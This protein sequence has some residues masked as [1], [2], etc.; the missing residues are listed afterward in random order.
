[1]DNQS[2]FHFVL[3][4]LVVVKRVRGY[5]CIDSVIE[6]TYCT[7]RIFYTAYATLCVLLLKDTRDN[8]SYSS[9]RM[10]FGRSGT[11]KC[12]E[13]LVFSFILYEI[14]MLMKDSKM[15][16]VGDETVS[17]IDLDGWRKKP[18]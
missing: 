14:Y 3:P 16:S 7:Y 13:F 12:N 5:H 4:L 17:Y 2:R 15:L 9:G 10:L 6:Y 11:P 18:V 1:M 8:A